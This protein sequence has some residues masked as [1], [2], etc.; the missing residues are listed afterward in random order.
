[1]RF[2]FRPSP[3][4]PRLLA[5]ITFCL[6]ALLSL[7]VVA[8][9]AGTAASE[10][11]ATDTSMRELLENEQKAE[12]LIRER[13]AEIRANDEHPRTPLQ[14]ILLLS[15]A[16]EDKDFEKAARYLDMRYLP[17][18]FKQEDGVNLLRA[19][20][21][22]WA[23]Q[24]LIDVTQ[25]SDQAE[26]K[27]ND[28]L[29]EYRD[30]LGLIVMDS[31]EEV[32]VYLQRIPDGEGGK[33][34]KISNATVA[35]IPRLW[36]D[37]GYGPV[38]VW[39]QQH[40]PDVR[41]AGM[42]S[43]QLIATII[44][45]IVSW[46]LAGL[47]S[48]AIMRLALLIPNRFP[49]GIRQ[50][51]CRPFRLFLFVVI[52]RLLM[53][54]LALSLAARVY[55]NSSGVDYI[56]FSILVLGGI[57]LFRDYQIRRLDAAGNRHYVALLKPFTTIVKFVALMLIALIWAD[58]AGYNMS[59]IIA[60]LG[61]GSL[62]V[63][64]AAQKTL[65]NV[66]GAITLY[67]AR[68]VNP[69]DLCRFGSIIG[70]VEEIGLRST[71]IRTLNRTMLAVPNSVFSSVEVENFSHRDRIR[72]FQ[73]LELQMSTADQLRVT[74]GK[75]REIFLSHADL[76]QESVS[77]RLEKIAAATAVIRIDAHVSTT[78]YQHFLAV[79]EDLNLRIIET[80]HEAGTVFSGPGQ[81]LQL[82]EFYEA[83]EDTMKEVRNQ[84]DTW[85]TGDNL[86]FPD[87]SEAEK[88]AMRAGI[89]LPERGKSS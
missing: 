88:T 27:L 53:D 81:V 5:A 28:G 41:F 45:A 19:L 2:T 69:G 82:R 24:N 20:R 36:D 26:G 62:A 4:F 44:F 38:A 7:A 47:I 78:D 8:Q 86:P 60:G 15:E 14:L 73:Q 10:L 13:S 52:L 16:G 66:I 61:V 32:P 79:A 51:F 71:T 9:D 23:Q 70:V 65:E 18:S 25:I 58:R 76:L 55:L 50:F 12:E 63:A 84:L 11:S 37:L 57:S 21:V 33:I 72:Y 87:F 1:M 34:W 29:P 83:S 3:H 30:L 68:P 64:L 39:L 17:E 67:T 89:S 35:E 49:D 48:F 56:A 74:L 43:W 42:S 46:P 59:T 31:G 75:L 77:V 80:V 54:E 22:V 85:R 40:L 6:A